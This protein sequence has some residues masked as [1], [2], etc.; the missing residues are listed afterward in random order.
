M[1]RT[2]KQPSDLRSVPWPVR[3]ARW[4][5][6]DVQSID[7][8]HTF[9]T[10]RNFI[11]RDGTNIFVKGERIVDRYGVSNGLHALQNFICHAIEIQHRFPSY[12]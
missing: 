1:D 2:W 8:I 3:A 12:S 11:P 7:D 5:A 10:Y 6:A 4:A 9:C